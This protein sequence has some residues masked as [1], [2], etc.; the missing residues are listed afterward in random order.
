MTRMVMLVGVM[1][2]GVGA[3]AQAQPR[4]LR[5]AE[6][7][8]V[9]VIDAN[10]QEWQGRLLKVSAEALEI[11]SDAGVRTFKLADIRRV[12]AD[13]DGVWDGALKGAAVGAALGLLAAS[14]ADT[15]LWPMASNAMSFG[16]IGLAID[17][18]CSARHPVYHNAPH[19]APAALKAVRAVHV[20]M[21][22]KW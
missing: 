21:R 15:G 3:N 22:M 18:G 11:E 16:L 14:A 17:G 8:G 12:D 6:G 19:V 13:G 10:R 2:L 1:A 9:F 7:R 20:S 4:Q 5:S